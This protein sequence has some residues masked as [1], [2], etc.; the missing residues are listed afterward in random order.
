M[1]HKTLSLNNNNTTSCITIIK[2]KSQLLNSHREALF[3][4]PIITK[5]PYNNLLIKLLLPK[6][7]S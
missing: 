4:K 2:L 5:D 6:I 7:A 3:T 1:T